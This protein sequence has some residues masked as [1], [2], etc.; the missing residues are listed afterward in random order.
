ML[1]YITDEIEK[2]V[3]FHPVIIIHQHS[4]VGNITLKIEEFCQLGFYCF[5]V[6][7]QSFFIKQISFRRLHGGV[8]NHSRGTPYKGYGS[9]PGTLKV[10]Q[11][12]YPHQMSYMQRIGCGIY[13]QVAG[14]L[15]F[16]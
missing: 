6:M 4:S 8:A 1:S 9:M 5:L 12:H 3:I 7:P 2:S 15:F 16:H 14:G 10:L 11:H 13:S